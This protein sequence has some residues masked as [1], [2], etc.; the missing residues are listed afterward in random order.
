VIDDKEHIFKYEVGPFNN[1]EVT[2]KKI[3]R[4]IL[5]SSGG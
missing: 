2:V 4:K 1:K 3:L 5:S